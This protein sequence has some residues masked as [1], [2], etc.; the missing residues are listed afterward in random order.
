MISQL[1][2]DKALAGETVEHGDITVM[3]IVDSEQCDSKMLRKSYIVHTA[4]TSQ[5]STVLEQTWY[6]A[7]AACFSPTSLRCRTL[8]SGQGT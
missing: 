7:S 4:G 3:V 5:L 2:S 8:E 1:G 6:T